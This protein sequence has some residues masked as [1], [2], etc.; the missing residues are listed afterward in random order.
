[1]IRHCK[2]WPPCAEA[3][4]QH[5]QSIADMCCA[6]GGDVDGALT[7]WRIVNVTVARRCVKLIPNSTAAQS[8]LLAARRGELPLWNPLP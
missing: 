6:L 4:Q 1:M 3:R 2:H 5:Q 7:L 8:L